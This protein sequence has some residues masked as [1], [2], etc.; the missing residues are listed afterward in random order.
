MPSAAKIARWRTGVF[1]YNRV[2]EFVLE[3]EFVRRLLS[4]L[5]LSPK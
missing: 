1:M 4:S 3:N 5:N 2:S